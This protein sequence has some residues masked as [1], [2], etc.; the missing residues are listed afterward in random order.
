MRL[1][2]FGFALLL[3]AEALAG[4]GVTPVEVEVPSGDEAALIAALEEAA[5]FSAYRIRIVRTRGDLVPFRFAREHGG[6]GTFLPP[7]VSNVSIVPAAGELGVLVFRGDGSTL[8]ARRLAEVREGG[9]LQILRAVFEGFQN[10]GN[11][12]AFLVRDTGVLRLDECLFRGNAALG[13][14]GS[15][16]AQD[17]SAVFLQR[18]GFT[19]NL[20]EAGG[21]AIMTSGAAVLDAANVLFTGNL[22]RE[23]CAVAA[24]SALG[25]ARNSVLLRSATFLFGCDI[26]G[27]PP[28][29]SVAD[30]RL[31]LQGV[32]FFGA[33]RAIDA[34]APV[35]LYGSLL[36]G[37]GLSKG[38]SGLCQGDPDQYESLGFN[39]GTDGS[40]SLDQETDQ[41]NAEADAEEQNG[42]V[43]LKEGSTAIDA[44]AAELQAAIAANLGV[45][46]PCGYKDSRDLGRPQ[47]AD[48]DGDFQCDIGDFEVQGGPDLSVGHSAAYFDRDRPGEGVFLE[49]LP[50]GRAFAGF[51]TYRADADAPAWFVGVGQQMGNS[52]VFDDLLEVTGGRFGAGFDPSALERTRVAGMSMIFSTCQVGD[53]QGKLAFQA[54][55]DSPYADLLTDAVRLTTVVPCSGEVPANAE[56]SGSFF[57]PDREGEGVFVQWLPDGH[58]LVIWYTFDTEG[59]PLWIISA[60][61]EVIGNTV[62]ATMLY[63][64]RAT[65]F[66]DDF[67]E[68]AIELA[69][70]GELT[71]EY[72]GCDE[73]ALTYDS[74]IAGFGAGEYGYQRLTSLAGTN[75][76]AARQR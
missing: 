4:R 33:D 23:G 9:Q 68:A 21:G 51:F 20:A 24:A 71:L 12:G 75:C 59:E 15:I 25:Q 34:A 38:E 36:V 74:P 67:D 49:L 54:D 61:T 44:G 62:R 58:V 2:I 8:I 60:D 42:T 40:C 14:G 39:L 19:A 18:C 27:G 76:S 17:Q 16:A 69:E 26:S 46:L 47:D 55:P 65:R 10:A 63:P 28:L 56:R 53:G 57:D 48:G 35:R 73:I 32:T 29:V 72:A 45:G 13:G 3:S 30:G 11:G 22:A 50:D 52:V 6:S 5:Q 7:I 64:Q 1:L 66:G 43:A 70:W 41:P 31:A 37:T